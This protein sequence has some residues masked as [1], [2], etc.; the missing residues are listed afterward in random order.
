MVAATAAGFYPSLTEAAMAMEQGG[1]SR[2]CDPNARRRFDADYRIFLEMHT[3]RQRLDA[4]G[5]DAG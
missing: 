5:A 1:H 2:E 4:L 3:Q